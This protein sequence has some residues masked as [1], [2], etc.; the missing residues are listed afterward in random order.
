ME[1]N[2]YENFFLHHEKEGNSMFQKTNLKKN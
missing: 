2:I 1:L